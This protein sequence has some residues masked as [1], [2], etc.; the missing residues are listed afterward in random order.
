[1]ATAVLAVPYVSPVSGLPRLAL[2]IAVGALV[3]L[4]MLRMTGAIN[5]TDGE[6]ILHI[7][8]RMPGRIR[9]LVERCVSLLAT[10]VA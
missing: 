7:G 8:R 9:P 5:K 10:E 6:R 1:M 4:G 2:M 3:W